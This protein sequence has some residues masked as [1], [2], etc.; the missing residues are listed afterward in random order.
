LQIN[1]Q[2]QPMKHKITSTIVIA[3]IV[4]STGFYASAAQAKTQDTLQKN[5]QSSTNVGGLIEE[6]RG[7]IDEIKSLIGSVTDFASD[8]PGKLG[9][10]VNGALG[11]FGVPDLETVLADLTGSATADDESA[12]VAEA[13]EGNMTGKGTDGKGSFAIREDQAGRAAREAAV[14]TASAAT[15]SDKAQERMVQ[16]AQTAAQAVQENESLAEDSQGSD[17]TQY[18]MQN[19]SQQTALN[20]RVNQQILQESQ[21]ARV[22]RAIG[23]QLDAQMAKELA[24]AN[25]ADRREAM[26]ASSTVIQYSG[27]VMMPGGHYLGKQD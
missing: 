6:G 21:Q 5:A 23:I 26:A 16:N 17:V 20:A 22:D 27:M 2:K 11:A 9:E 12:Q 19:L 18:I 10:S 15:L 14:E 7:L 1:L 8:L 3:T 24:G 25:I 13:L 4:L